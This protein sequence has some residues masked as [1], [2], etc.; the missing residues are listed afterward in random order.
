MSL[1]KE[2]MSRLVCSKYIYRKGV[3]V[4]DKEGY[5]SS[6][7]GILHFQDSIEMVLRVIAEHI[8][9]N[10]K[11]TA[12]FNQIIDSINSVDIKKIPFRSALNQINR[13]RVNFKHS[14]L[15]PTRKDVLKFKADLE[16]FFPN[17]VKLFFD[18]DFHS[19]SLISLI[20]HRRIENFLNKSEE[21]I[22]A[23]NYK[24]SICSSAISFAIFNSY[25]ESYVTYKRD[26]F[27][28]FND[29]DLEKW[30]DKIEETLIDQQFQLNLIMNGINPAHY[31]RFQN[32]VPG[33]SISAAGTY[34]T[35][36]TGMSCMLPPTY[37]NA[38]FCQDFV[39]EAIIL[40]KENKPPSITK[41]HDSSRKFDVISEGSIIV[42]PCDDHEIIRTTEIGEIL[43]GR[44][45]NHD[46]TGYFAIFLD[47]DTAF[48][49]S[50]C[51][52]LTN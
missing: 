23:G 48:V 24:D 28:K 18:I 46:K 47:G 49:E 27:L 13:A 11:E 17:V 10:L 40:T 25:F 37:E 32:C 16:Q 8:H 14:G 30:A 29:L 51:V 3:D 45:E 52:T 50:S 34:Q 31:K 20:G 44:H 35:I 39:I 9:C 43:Y 19:I 6:G 41:N 21:Q 1:E 7:L 26:H 15:E 4:I 2:L 22:E 42:W 38:I 33:V 5:F 12:A 36:Y